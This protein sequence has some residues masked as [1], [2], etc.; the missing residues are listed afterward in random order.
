MSRQRQTAYTAIRIEGGLIPADEIARLTTLAQPEATEQTDGHYGTPRGP[1]LR[2][3]IAR[4]FK[5]AQNFWQEFQTV[6]QRT[7]VDAHAI[8]VNTFLLPLLRDSLGYT[9]MARST[10]L[11]VGD[12][13]YQ[14][15][16]AALNGRL[17]LVLAAHD[18]PL[19]QSRFLG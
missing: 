12:H 15:V 1:K 2:D 3:E 5:I 14:I 6:R 11:T 16:Q 13:T 7:G 8:T 10:G 9:D 18:Q 19:D 17:P 4:Y